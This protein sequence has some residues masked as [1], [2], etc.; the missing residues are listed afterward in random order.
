[1]VKSMNTFRAIPVLGAAL[2][3]AVTVA[4]CAEILGLGDPEL[5]PLL[6]TGG[7]GAGGE[8]GTTSSSA[9]GGTGGGTGATGGAGGTGAAG[10]AGGTG[11]TGGSVGPCALTD[12]SCT[13]FGSKC[14]ALYDNAGKD[15]FALRLSQVQFFKPSAFA[16]GFEQGFVLTA[17]NPAAPECHV[18]GS[19]SSSWIVQIDRTAKTV[20]IG[21]AKPVADPVDGYSFVNETL[22]QSGQDFLV[23][24]A[25]APYTD[26]GQGGLQTEPIPTV[27]VPA[28]LDTA[29]QNVMLLPIHDLVFTEVKVSADQNCIGAF[30]EWGLDPAQGCEQDTNQGMFSFVSDAK[31]EGHILLEEADKVI[32]S[33]LGI[34]RSL[35]VILSESPN[36][37]GDGGNPTRCKRSNGKIQ[38]PGDWCS[39]EKGPASPVCADAVRFSASLAASGVKLNP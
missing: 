31:A 2:L 8:A 21:G 18:N 30:N 6:G 26:D 11:G 35:C 4:G 14:I 22:N 7:G 3:A 39:T 32:V 17:F 19:G 1:M 9:S 25:T 24:P 36:L 10:G 16:G 5:D 34:N 12:P 23:A 28:Y 20:T 15:N 29:G 27:V 13:Q 38:F 33:L 37:W